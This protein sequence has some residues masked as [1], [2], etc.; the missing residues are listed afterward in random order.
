[1]ATIVNSQVPSGALVTFVS[2]IK[3][4]TQSDLWES[5]FLTDGS[6]VEEK[7][8]SHCSGSRKP[9]EHIVNQVQEVESEL[10]VR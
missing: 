2:V 5:L 1:M 3:T 7:L 9:K 6:T 4:M 10:E 8:G